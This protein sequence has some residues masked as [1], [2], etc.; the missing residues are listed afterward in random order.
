M[1]QTLRYELPEVMIP[2]V[3]EGKPP[4]FGHD[5]LQLWSFD[6]N[7]LNFNNGGSSLG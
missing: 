6:P 7:Y 3:P 5:M 2:K 1:S 4:K